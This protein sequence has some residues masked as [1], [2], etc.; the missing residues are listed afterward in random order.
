MKNKFKETEKPKKEGKSPGKFSK[1]FADVLNGNFLTRDNVIGH[2]PF[3]FYICFLMLCYIGYGYFAEKNVKDLVRIE[4]ELK[5]LK[6]QSLTSHSTLEQI[7][8]Q[9]RIAEA[10]KELGLKESRVPP[11]IIKAI[12]EGQDGPE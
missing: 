8:Q 4:A 6:A 3:I 10:I 2:L 1:G 11:K 12:P 7:K 5:D 9:S